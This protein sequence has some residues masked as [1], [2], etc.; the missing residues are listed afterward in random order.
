MN[1]ITNKLMRQPNYVSLYTCLNLK[2]TNY[3]LDLNKLYAEK[4]L[5]NSTCQLDK[6]M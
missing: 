2:T 5:E 4:N 3:F 1:F 6:Y